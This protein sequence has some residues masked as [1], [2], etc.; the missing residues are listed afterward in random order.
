MGYA[1]RPHG[2][3]EFFACLAGRRPQ[4]FGAKPPLHLTTGHEGLSNVG[5]KERKNAPCD[6][7][8]GDA[9]RTCCHL[10]SA[11]EC[12]T[13]PLSTVATDFSYKQAQNASPTEIVGTRVLYL[14]IYLY[15]Y[16]CRVESEGKGPGSAHRCSW[17]RAPSWIAAVLTR[18][19]ESQTLWCP[20]ANNYNR[21]S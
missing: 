7:A 19:V 3:V 1:S 21:L 9:L 12:C 16:I 6:Y 4:G 10:T 15:I 5:A 2:V 14:S 11:A 20:S 17:N 13:V 18:A 8:P